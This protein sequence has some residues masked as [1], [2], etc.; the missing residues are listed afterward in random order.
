MNL[1][2]SVVVSP[3]VVYQ[4]VGGEIILLDL[5]SEQYL[6]LKDVGARIWQLLQD[7]NEL[8]KIF[9]TLLREYEVDSDKLA[10]DLSELLGQLSDE[11]LITLRAAWIT[12]TEQKSWSWAIYGEHALSR[13]ASVQAHRGMVFDNLR[14][15]FYAKAIQ[16][17]IGDD[18]VVLDLGAGLGLHGLIAAAG[19][20]AKVYLV[21]PSPVAEVARQLVK[22][23]GL[24]DRVECL[25]GRIED[26]GVPE[27]VDVIVSVFTGN[28]LLTEDLLPSLFHARDRYLKPGGRLIPDCATMEVAP[29][30]APEYYAK[31]VDCW[32]EPSFGI[33]LEIC[34]QHAANSPLL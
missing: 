1:N 26:I 25:I 23:N 3:Q 15:R 19:G 9:D 10:A 7:E 8:P 30:S 18:T 12:G 33:N 29:V 14:N 32:G 24:Q 34:R 28:F 21:E 13:Y 27:R 16:Q 4:E 17:A 6:G 2:Q 31:H 11:K 20:A 22:A 5:A